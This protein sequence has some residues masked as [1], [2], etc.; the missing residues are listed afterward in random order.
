M[1]GK[2][3]GIFLS[4]LPRP[5]NLFV[6][7]LV[8]TLL[9]FALLLA[10]GIL[11]A[12]LTALVSRVLSMVFGGSF[13]FFIVNYLTWFGTVLHEFSH[14]VFAA[15]TGAKVTHISL[16]PHGTTLGHVDFTPRGPSVLQGLQ[17]SLSACAPMIAGAAAEAV[18]AAF[19]LPLAVMFW[20]KLLVGYLMVSILLHMSMSPEDLLNFFRGFV[21]TFLIVF[22]LFTA[23][24]AVLF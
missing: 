3:P 13:A 8:D 23:A 18:L 5:E 11:I 10:L 12:V 1:T 20:Q 7:A 24:E 19:V 4:L 21:P 2:L 14:A 22:C 16:L 9:C 6:R 15:L 17:L